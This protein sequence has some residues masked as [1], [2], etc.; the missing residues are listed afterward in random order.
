MTLPYLLSVQDLTVTFSDQENAVKAVDRIRFT[1][2]AGECLGIVGASGSGKS[3]T[4]LSIL[5]LT[6]YLP[7][8]QVEGQIFFG[9]ASVDIL[10]L[11]APPLQKLRGNEI[12]LV[13]QEPMTAL[14]PVF[15]CGHQVEEV[16]RLHHPGQKGPAKKWVLELLAQVELKDPNRVYQSYSHELSGG[17]KQRVL[18]A[19]ALAGSPRLLIADEPTSALDVTV[20]RELIQLLRR[21]QHEMG[22]GLIFISHDLGVIRAIS[23]RVVVM[24]QGVI[25]EEGITTEVLDNPQQ[26]YTRSL[27]AARPPLD[28]Q[29]DRLAEGALAEVQELSIV[30][31][32]IQKE[33]LKTL[34]QK[35]AVLEVE[36]L[37]VNF[38]KNLGW[39]RKQVV[40]AVTG[41]SFQLYPGERLGI[42]GESGSG[43][44]TTGKAL[45]G[46]VPIAAGTINMEGRP[47]FRAGEG[48]LAIRHLSL[49]MIFQDPYGSLDPRMTVGSSLQEALRIIGTPK[50]H[51]EEMAGDWL[52]RVGLTRSDLG[53]YP[54]QF[55]GGQRQRICIARALCLQPQVLICDESVSALDV[56]IQAQIL[57]LLKDLSDQLGFSLVFISHDISVIRFLCDRV[58]VM[59][60]GKVVE[61]GPVWKVFDQ[62]THPYTQRLLEAVFP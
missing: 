34:S 45:V 51:R 39:G 49:Q 57:N 16:W 17:Q 8:C 50:A 58:L 21:L 60:A 31:E 59:E 25:V 36:D 42:V 18:I 6:D 48:R 15:K 7:A 29:V 61:Q 5:R 40:Q 10:H 27:L 30:S 37:S 56:S 44:T 47:L 26:P 2:A 33:R 54:F 46:L 24:E 52:E 20:Q 9:E 19:M 28:H 53:K 11:A 38:T 3:M 23:D 35:E 32:G 1:V 12:A 41:L 14:N 4:A 22:L 62:P 55:S 13:F 43:K